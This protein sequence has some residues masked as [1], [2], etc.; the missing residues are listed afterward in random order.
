MR[1]QVA[2]CPSEEGFAVSCP[3]LPGCW[4]QGTTEKEA[5]GNIETAIAEYLITIREAN[6]NCQFREVEVAY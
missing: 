3:A 5:L 2:L 4:S 1:Y 6:K